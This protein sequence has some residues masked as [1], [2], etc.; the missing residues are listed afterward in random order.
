MSR[1][2]VATCLYTITRVKHDIQSDSPSMLILIVFKL[3]FLEFLNVP[4]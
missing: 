3:W 1:D 2:V 4:T